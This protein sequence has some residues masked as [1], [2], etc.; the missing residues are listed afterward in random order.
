MKSM[1]RMICV[2]AL[3]CAGL[4]GIWVTG[5]SATATTFPAAGLSL[6][7]GPAPPSGTPGVKVKGDCPS[8]LFND[9]IGLTF[10]SGNA[11]SYGP[12]PN[13]MTFGGNAEGNGV[14]TDNGS[15]TSYQGHLHAWFGVNVNPTG[16]AQNYNG[17]TVSFHGSGPAGSIQLNASFGGGSS[18]S[19][20]PTDWVQL[21]ISCS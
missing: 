8:F 9:D 17:T 15:A 4:M 16:N 13:P 12:T 21:D 11:V 2:F 1:I 3:A 6:D 14:L 20:R 19:G 7:L 5:A 10:T 18:A